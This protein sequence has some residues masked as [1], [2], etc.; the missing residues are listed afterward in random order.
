MTYSTTKTE[1]VLILP[2]QLLMAYVDLGSLSP[3]LLKETKGDYY[4]AFN[5][6]KQ[7]CS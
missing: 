4:S 1:Q 5:S 6:I 3:L 7:N 2:E